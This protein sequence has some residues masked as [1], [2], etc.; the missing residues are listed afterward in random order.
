MNLEKWICVV[1]IYLYQ[2]QQA[3]GYSGSEGIKT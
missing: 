2:Q 3:S 1:E